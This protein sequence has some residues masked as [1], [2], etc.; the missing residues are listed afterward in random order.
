MPIWRPSNG[1]SPAQMAEAP[2]LP[3]VHLGVQDLRSAAVAEPA[4]APSGQVALAFR[5]RT[6]GAVRA[7]V[8]RPSSTPAN[9]MARP[10]MSQGLFR[11]RRESRCGRCATPRSEAKFRANSGGERW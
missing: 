10:P 5:D 11:L 4:T 7:W 2:S 6:E 3:V 8:T 1:R 9:G